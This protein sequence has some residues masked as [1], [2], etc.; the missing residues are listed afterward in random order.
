MNPVARRVGLPAG[1][2]SKQVKIFRKLELEFFQP[3]MSLS[4]RLIDGL[5]LPRHGKSSSELWF[6]DDLKPGGREQW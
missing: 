1:K 5:S 4:A 3:L 6:S 2:S